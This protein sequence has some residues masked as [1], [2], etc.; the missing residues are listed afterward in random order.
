[1]WIGVVVVVVC[2]CV[3]DRV[4]VV[5]IWC[6]LCCCVLLLLLLLL[7]CCSCCCM[8]FFVCVVACR[9]VCV[10]VSVVDGV[11]VWVVFL[12]CWLYFCTSSCFDCHSCMFVILSIVR[13]SI[14]SRFCRVLYYIVCVSLCCPLVF[15]K[16]V[17]SLFVCVV[18]R[19]CFGIVVWFPL[20]LCLFCCS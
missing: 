8:C 17:I 14:G 18:V 2:V 13:V 6:L 19:V 15:L 12:C 20:V 3:A 10:V 1:M 7:W 5:C 11:V 9:A 4:L 16:L